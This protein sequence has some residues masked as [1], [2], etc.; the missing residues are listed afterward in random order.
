MFSHLLEGYAAEILS[1]GK[2]F[3]VY[4]GKKVGFD[5]ENYDQLVWMYHC[6]FF[7]RRSMQMTLNSH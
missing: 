7:R 4:A 1:D 3:S 6:D 2:D 5:S